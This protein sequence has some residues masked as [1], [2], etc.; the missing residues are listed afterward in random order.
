MSF[1]GRNP[2][3]VEVGNL[4]NYLQ[5]FIHPRRCRISSIDSSCV[6]CIFQ[7]LN[8]SSIGTIDWHLWLVLTYLTLKGSHPR[9]KKTST[10]QIVSAWLDFLISNFWEIMNH[11]I[12]SP[13]NK[14]S[15]QRSWTKTHFSTQ[16]LSE[17]NTHLGFPSQVRVWFDLELYSTTNL[18]PTHHF[19]YPKPWVSRWHFAAAFWS[20]ATSWRHREFHTFLARNGGVFSPER[21]WQLKDLGQFS[22]RKLGK[23]SNLTNTYFSDGLV[24][25][26]TG[27]LLR[28]LFKRRRGGPAVEI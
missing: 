20:W 7:T 19:T 6:N 18:Q 12:P 8:Q 9:E 15:S 11:D 25:P 10:F 14:K 2:A 16:L 24:Q 21:W 5:G 23:W 4:Y 3:P 17:K 1:F 27:H 26:P 13:P 28:D 22:S